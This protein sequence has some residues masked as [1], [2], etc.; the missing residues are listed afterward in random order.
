MKSEGRTTKPGPSRFIVPPSPFT[1]EILS[2]TNHLTAESWRL[3]AARPK[4]IYKPSSVPSR[5]K[6]VTIHLRRWLPAA[7]SDQ[8]EDW[9]GACSR[10][11]GP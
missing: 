10:G 3:I 4:Q 8:P 5:G 9:A 7:S 1:L 11:R 2:E 6:A